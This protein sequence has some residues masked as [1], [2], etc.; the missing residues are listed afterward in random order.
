MPVG[1]ARAGIFGSGSVI[2]DEDNLTARYDARELSLSDGETVST[3]P[4]ETGNGNDLSAVGSPTFRASAISGLPAV[5]TDGTNDR[6]ETSFG[7]TNAQPF[8]IFYLG[9]LQ[10]TSNTQTIYSDNPVPGS[11]FVGLQSNDGSYQ[12]KINGQTDPTLG[13][14]STNEGIISTLIDGSNST[15]RV[16]G[17]DI[18]TA[19]SGANDYD[20]LSIGGRA[21]DLEYAN[22]QITEILVYEVDESTNQTDIEQYL[23]R[24]TSLL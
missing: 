15:L 12:W 3:W 2:P 4:D 17:S 21:D 8:H 23:D 11:G 9:Q 10:T 24:D 6:L 14:S 18:G 5:E 1:A 7:T 22:I 16:N 19:D 20:G 13:S